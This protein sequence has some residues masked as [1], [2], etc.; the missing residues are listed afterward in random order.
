MNIPDTLPATPTDAIDRAAHHL[1]AAL[2]FL[3]QAPDEAATEAHT[4]VAYI[5]YAND[6]RAATRE[7]GIIRLF[8]AI[9]EQAIATR[10]EGEQA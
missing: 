6:L 2:A 5:A 10:E 3:D 9:R 7:R 8:D 1:Q 4:A